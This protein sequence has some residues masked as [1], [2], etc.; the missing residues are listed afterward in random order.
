MKS[1]IGLIINRIVIFI[2]L[3]ALIYAFFFCKNE[4]LC[5]ILIVFATSSIIVHLITPVVIFV[6]RKFNI[7][8]YP[9][10][11]KIHKEPTPRCGGIVVWSGVLCGLLVVSMRYMPNLKAMIAGSTAV[12][13]AGLVDD[14]YGL[15]SITRLLVQIAASFILILDGIHVTF[16]P[17]GSI[18]TIM[19]WI[20]TVI[21]IVG[22]TNA[23]NFM[24]GMDGL[25]SG[26]IVC[27][28]IMY[29]ILSWLIDSSM[30]AY[31][32][33]ALAATGLMF[34]SYNFKPA[35]IFLGDG[36]STFFG[37]FVA[38]LGVHGTWA[39]DSLL[40]S[41]FV[42][43]LLLSVF[44]YDMCFITVERV[45][46][47]KVKSLRQWFDYTGK[48]HLHHRLEALGLSRTTVVIVIWMLNFSVG[49]ISVA[50]HQVTTFGGIAILFAVIGIYAI[51]ALFEVLAAK[52]S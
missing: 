17:P 33:I 25:V 11:R 1:S 39:K 36:G 46:S 23:V 28:G 43:V 37:F 45:L 14:I 18:W 41:F 32:G 24:D 13:I 40:V 7:L 2:C 15:S 26:L 12:M 4:F 9:D 38:S 49:L 21:W 48:D 47:G 16:L 29:F 44:I 20:I 3:L 6:S 42:P 8:D 34:L 10:E 35:R 19:E 52:K 51:I 31:C 30:L 27:T 5:A 22:I 50:L